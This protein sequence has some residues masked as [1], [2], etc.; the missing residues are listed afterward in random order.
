MYGYSHPPRAARDLRE[1]GIPLET[2]KMKNSLGRIIAAYRFASPLQ[3]DTREFVGRRTFPKQFKQ[4]LLSV[5]G[6]RCAVCQTS[7]ESHYLQI[8][9]CIP[10]SIPSDSVLER[11]LQ[12]FM[13][14]CA[15]CNRAKAWSCEHCPNQAEKS[16]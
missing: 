13:L 2:L 12:D 6:K 1:L 15:T 11:T 5:S 3:G 10:Y 16:I 4:R 14:L 7:L 9:H 8:D